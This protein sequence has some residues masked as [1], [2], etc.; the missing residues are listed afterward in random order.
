MALFRL[1]RLPA[2][3]LRLF[4][5]ALGLVAGLGAQSLA[6]INPPA[7][8][9]KAQVDDVVFFTFASPARIE[10][11]DM[12]KRE[13]LSSIALT[14]SPTAFA[15]DKSGLTIA[16]GRA[17][18]TRDLDGTDETALYNASYD[19]KALLHSPDFIVAAYTDYW[20][21][22][23]T[24]I[25]RR[26]RQFIA[27]WSQTYAMSAGFSIDPANR[28]IYGV[29]TFHS[30]ANTSSVTYNAD[31][32]WPTGYKDAGSYY[33]T[34][35][36][37]PRSYVSPDGA[38]LVL[39]AGYIYDPTSL[40]YRASLAGVVEDLAFQGSDT[41]IVLRDTQLVAYGNTFLESGSIT[42]AKAAQG[43][44]I[45]GDAVFA[46]SADATAS[47]GISAAR[48]AISSFSSA[49]PGAAPEPATLSFI[50]DK[51]IPSG[52]DTFFLYSKT[53]QVIFEWSAKTGAYGAAYPLRGAPAVIAYSAALN[54][55]Y[56]GYT[57][58]E[59]RQIKLDEGATA[60]TPFVN[61][62]SSVATLQA[63]NNRIL[64]ANSSSYGQFA[65]EL[66]DAQGVKKTSVT[67]YNLG[68]D[69]VWSPLQKRLFFAYS[70]YLQYV[71]V[72]VDDA[73]SVANSY[74]SSNVS[75]AYP[76]R[77]SSGETD[78]L[79]GNGHIFG[80]TSLS[81]IGSLANSVTDAVSI[82]NRWHS[83][84]P[85]G[86]DT[87]LQLWSKNYLF[88]RGLT[89]SGYPLRVFGLSDGRLLVLTASST[90][91][92]ND[93]YPYG[94]S[95]SGRVLFSY[96]N[97]AGA[98]TVSTPAYVVTPPAPTTVYLGRPASMTV[99]AGGTAPYT[100]QWRFKDDPIAGAT[101]ATFTLA[102][103]K[104]GDAGAYTVTVANAHG[105]VTSRPAILTVAA[106]PP[107]PVIVTEPSGGVAIIGEFFQSL[108]VVASGES[109]SYQWY[110]NDKAIDGATSRY[111]GNIWSFDAQSYGDYHVV[112]SNPGGE[113]RSRTV[114]IVPPPAPV[115]AE[116]PVDVYALPGDFARFS[117]SFEGAGTR[118]Q[119]RRDGTNLPDRIFSELNIYEVR[120]LD[121]GRYDV[122]ITNTAG[123]VTS[124][125]ARLIRAIPATIATA[126][127]PQSVTLGGDVAFTVTG[128]GL[129]ASFEYLWQRYSPV[130]KR[131]VDI[132]ADLPHYGGVGTATLEI[133]NAPSALN[134]TEVRC[135]VHNGF[136]DYAV[137]A[138]AVLT[139]VATPVD[140]SLRFTTEPQNQTVATGGVAVF[141]VATN[142]TDP[143]SYQWYLDGI[144]VRD[145]TGAS[146]VINPVE[147]A[148]AGNYTVIARSG[149]STIVS[150]A[151]M[152]DVPL[153]VYAPVFTSAP[154]DAT[155][156]LGESL[157][158]SAGVRAQPAASL[159]WR[160]GKK[161]LTKANGAALTLDPV[162][163]GDAGSYSVTA[164]NSAG[165]VT[166]TFRV[167]VIAPPPAA[168]PDLAL[169][170]GSIV[171]LELAGDTTVVGLR[172]LASGLPDGLK[173]DAATGRL[174]G[175]V[176]GKPKTYSPRF[177]TQHGSMKSEILAATFTVDAFPSALAGGYE[178]LIHSPDEMWLPWGKMQLLV[179]ATGGFTGTLSTTT[180]PAISLRGQLTPNLGGTAA[181][182]SVSIPGG[183]LSLAISQ[184][185][186]VEVEIA[187]SGALVAESDL[188]LRS[189]TPADDVVPWAGAYTLGFDA[190]AS[191]RDSGK[192]QPAGDGYATVNIDP[193]GK[194]V[195]KGRLADGTVLTASLV[196]GRGQAYDFAPAYL[197]FA[198]P[199]K[200]G[201]NYF[202]GKVRLQRVESTGTP[203]YGIVEDNGSSMFF[204]NKPP[205]AG[206]ATYAAGFGPLILQLRMQL[207]LP[208][209]RSNNLAVLLGL[210]RTAAVLRPAAV[211]ED[212]IA[213]STLVQDGLPGGLLLS[214]DNK[215]MLD[216]NTPAA[217]AR[218]WRF[219]VAPAT[220]RFTGTLLVPADPENATKARTVRFEGV[221]FQP[222][223]EYAYFVGRGF[224]LLPPARAGEAT[225]SCAFRLPTPE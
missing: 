171:N 123:S 128:D 154:S 215:F 120:E 49:V 164:T 125:P 221:L 96:V 78:L 103:V 209:T 224:L 117:V 82:D 50:P 146:L 184:E 155:A 196:S 166:V 220:G 112:V 64:A 62:S 177:W 9:H 148:N 169:R 20:N 30:G 12:V 145:A 70:S 97:L 4:A 152:L 115:I 29:N 108:E 100:Y 69:F 104:D 6:L 77:L 217:T 105:S 110:R 135:L 36:Q 150:R 92:N 102:N 147:A 98:G 113:A 122:V 202:A 74:V 57:T 163:A 71:S 60:E 54:R 211:R 159:V 149:A 87:Q 175:A 132:G 165:S 43:V 143:V 158:L 205:R 193:T 198:R 192:A 134:G 28:R 10:R 225:E 93:Y 84:R 27:T 106:P 127:T 201:A 72:S 14:N 44:A 53:Y 51:I 83:I 180:G 25:R 160:L 8:L 139:V 223:I 55:L 144:E 129:P 212:R 19:V 91:T 216:S 40:T 81:Y 11:Y 13:W 197:W 85:T 99:V 183:T 68:S 161:V 73:L 7:W 32:T 76:L 173:L 65:Y 1:N 218:A 24:T 179:A 16:Y 210:D 31:G 111:L 61:L 178:V 187:Q 75:P 52:D 203:R 138:A 185:T 42:L 153:G 157:S 208:P 41:S 195:A 17:I 200:A 37:E 131:W 67:N 95:P 101:S 189:R 88:E 119:W 199:Y 33:Y 207:W 162:A 3:I 80:T 86:N 182:A 35:V 222:G 219:T 194:F 191:P 213:D 79:G 190:S 121:F 109:L 142:A 140:N 167:A 168:V 181:L 2:Q 214:A 46:F 63:V 176:T 39:G 130:L 206:A 136:G 186:G 133:I 151:G 56:T 34:S 26:D 204:W 124:R 174:T 94:V 5:L 23:L 170:V 118:V 156:V 15:A 59:V 116:D 66:F 188:F 137:S 141:V 172:Y 89:V 22:Y 58:G 18:Y 21:G 107:A 45:S 90:T 48:I 114:K 126:P 47:S 38:L